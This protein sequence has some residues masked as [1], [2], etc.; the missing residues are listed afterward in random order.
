MAIYDIYGNQ[1]QAV[2]DIEGNSL[3]YAYDIEGSQ[4][5]GGKPPVGTPLKVMTYNVQYFN[6]INSQSAM[7]NAI[8]SL[9]EPDIIGMQELGTYTASNLPSVGQ[10]MLANY[11]NKQF[12][13]HKNKVLMVTKSL[14]L[15]NVAI[16]DFENQDPQ[17]VS[18]YNETRAYMKA[19][20]TVGGKTI[21]WINTH[22]C[23][24]TKSVMYEQMAEVFAMAEQCEYVIITGD[25]NSGVTG[26]EENDYIYMY[27]QFVD[28]GYNLANN[29][30]TA[31]FVNTYAYLTNPTSLADL[32]TAPDSIIVSGNIDID[33]VVFDTTKFSYLNGSVIDHIPVIATLTIH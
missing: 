15:S 16:A 22:L 6:G 12:S 5:F 27:K 13:N 1:L 23:Y 14:A 17:D 8:I 32:Q 19:D 33:S 30:P 28:A 10:T 2:Y 24:L 25:F 11:P 26:L 9:Y 18:Q 31:G 4:I 20:I 21:T 7:Q 3:Q 29:S